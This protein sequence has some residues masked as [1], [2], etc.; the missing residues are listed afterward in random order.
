MRWREFLNLAVEKQ[1]NN[2]KLRKY[3]RTIMRY[4]FYRKNV[5]F[6][7]CKFTFIYCLCT[8][9]KDVNNDLESRN[10]YERRKYVLNYCFNRKEN[11]CQGWI[12]IPRECQYISEWKYFWK[13]SHYVGHNFW[14][15]FC[16]SMTIKLREIYNLPFYDSW[17]NGTTA[18][19]ITSGYITKNF[20]AIFVSF[21]AYWE[22]P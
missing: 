8:H 7:T 10:F 4:I 15:E 1:L 17:N 11:M 21:R 20:K 9:E 5:L 3:C 14:R 18:S 16:M 19:F 12:K 13:E 22:T 6:T 2:K